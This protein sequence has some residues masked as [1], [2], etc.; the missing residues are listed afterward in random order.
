MMVSHPGALL[1]ALARQAMAGRWLTV[2][3]RKVLAGSGARCVTARGWADGMWRASGRIVSARSWP[4][5]VLVLSL[6]GLQ[7]GEIAKLEGLHRVVPVSSPWCGDRALRTW[8]SRVAREG[9]RFGV[10]FLQNLNYAVKTPN[11]KV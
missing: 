1:Y 6:T 8:R 11:I 5:A 7:L 10:I 9:A 4:A 2:G 3:G